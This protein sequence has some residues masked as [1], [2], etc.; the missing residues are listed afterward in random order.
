MYYKGPAESY[1]VPTEVASNTNTYSAT[2]FYSQEVWIGRVNWG[3]QLT[4]KLGPQLFY[5]KALSQAEITQVFNTYR[6][7]FGL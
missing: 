5:T 4:G 2:T 6:N 1:T 3:D 7:R